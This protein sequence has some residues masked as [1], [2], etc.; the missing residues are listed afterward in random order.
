MV[1]RRSKVK[2]SF[3]NLPSLTPPTPLTD[4]W[5]ASLGKYQFKPFQ[6]S[7]FSGFPYQDYILR[8][9]VLYRIRTNEIEDKK[10]CLFTLTNLK[11]YHFINYY[12]KVRLFCRNS[13]ESALIRNFLRNGR[14]IVNTSLKW[15]K[16]SDVLVLTYFAFY[17][18]KFGVGPILLQLLSLSRWTGSWGTQI[19]NDKKKFKKVPVGGLG[20]VGEQNLPFW[21]T[22]FFQFCKR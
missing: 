22:F 10:R 14:V 4:F 19:F 5:C 11:S 15:K 9:V 6:L 17:E 3:F 2:E 18:Q 21:R 8:Q 16:L 1:F 12:K 7:F 13:D 20:Q